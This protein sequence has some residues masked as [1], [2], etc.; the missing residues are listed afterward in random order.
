MSVGAGW[1]EKQARRGGRVTR[2]QGRLTFCT[3]VAGLGVG[4]ALRWAP[5][6]KFSQGESWGSKDTLMG[7]APH[8][9]A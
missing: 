1:R 2:R 6:L 5:E 9:V 3:L 8:S 7:R 4:R